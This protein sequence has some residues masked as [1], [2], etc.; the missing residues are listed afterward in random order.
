[1]PGILFKV[2]CLISILLIITFIIWLIKKGLYRKNITE[3]FDQSCSYTFFRIIRYLLWI[4]S[5][6][7]ILQVIEIKI[8]VLMKG[9]AALLVGIGLGLQQ[10]F[11]QGA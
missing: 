10:V 1:M 6:T 7:L 9:S 8:T 3:S 11:H 2:V 5:F 4:F